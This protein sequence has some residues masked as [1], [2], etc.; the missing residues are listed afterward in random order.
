MS[1]RGRRYGPYFAFV[2]TMVEPR[3]F[4]SFGM[5]YLM[6]QLDFEDPWTQQIC[7]TSY[8]CVQFLVLSL[9]AYLYMKISAAAAEMEGKEQATFVVKAPPLPMGMENPE[10]DKEMTA[11]E[12]DMSKFLELVKQSAIGF[13]ICMIVYHKW[14]SPRILLLQVDKQSTLV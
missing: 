7:I 6:N 5:L 1:R 10:E 11:T 14:E 13:V 12:Y 3:M 8:G 9:Y 2:I 4:V